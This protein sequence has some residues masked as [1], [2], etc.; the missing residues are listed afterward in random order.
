MKRATRPDEFALLQL[1]QELRNNNVG[2][3][4]AARAFQNENDCTTPEPRPGG[5]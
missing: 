2:P 1:L 5:A 4:H 3:Q